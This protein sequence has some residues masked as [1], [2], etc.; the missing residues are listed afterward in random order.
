[1]P[2][3]KTFQKHI[4]PLSKSA[5]IDDHRGFSVEK[6]IN[7]FE[8][9]WI[10]FKVIKVWDCVCFCSAIP[11]FDS[12][13]TTSFMHVLRFGLSP[14]LP[15]V[16]QHYSILEKKKGKEN[17]LD[18]FP[19]FSFGPL[20]MSHTHSAGSSLSDDIMCCDCCCRSPKW[21]SGLFLCSCRQIRGCHCAGYFPAFLLYPHLML[22][23]GS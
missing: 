18:G 14:Q 17:L 9:W 21:A 7:R 16:A 8:K 11:T 10:Y 3:Q 22:T 19:R 6:P 20:V 5:L 1:M 12:L 23:F 15:N 2:L 4:C 13:I